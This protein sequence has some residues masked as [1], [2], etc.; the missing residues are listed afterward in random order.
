VR[1]DVRYGSGAI[2][3]V[4][5]LI[6]DLGA[7]RVLLVCGARSFEASGA[8]AI[9]P[10]LRR[11]ASVHRWS[12]FAPNPDLT[13]LARGL[14]IVEEL[15]PDLVLGI[16]GGTALD[17]AKLLCAFQGITEPEKLADAIRAGSPAGRELPLVLAPTTSGS[18]SEATHFAVVYIGEDKYSVAGGPL[19]PDVAILDPALT[20]SG[21]LYQR[22]SCGIDAV[23]QAIESLWAVAATERS[24]AWAR[25][26]LRLLV[27][28]I[29]RFVHE[30][31]DRCARAMAI[32][33]H[34]AG[35]AIDITRTTAAHALSYAITKRYGVSH[36]HAVALTLGGF[37]E[38]H[39]L[40]GRLREGVDP[41][42]HE[43]AM[44]E[45][46]HR[47]GAVDGAGGRSRFRALLDRLGLERPTVDIGIVRAVNL[48][49][50][51]NNPMPFEQAEL[52]AIVERE[53]R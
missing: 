6:A 17:L 43:R 18:G 9:L 34:L 44:A 29:E 48:Q 8:A 11:V 49:R 30:P 12:E 19:R 26:A 24:R 14:A 22:A 45:I 50:L 3:G 35:R 15:R 13:E 41:V 27:P 37:I 4:P 40:P 52:A 5:A 2:A 51:A 10:E 42:A 36:G 16:G 53:L 38:A 1:R 31:D 28:A 46:L 33:S 23:S 7:R 47:L 21:T 25:H 20:L 39:A 32:G